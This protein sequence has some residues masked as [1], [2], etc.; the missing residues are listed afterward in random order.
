MCGASCHKDLPFFRDLQR[1]MSGVTEEITTTGAGHE[2][3]WLMAEGFPT[4]S[5]LVPDVRLGV[6]T[7]RSSS[8][9][10]GIPPGV[11]GLICSIATKS[12]LLA[13]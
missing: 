13:K 8:M 3:L 9:H 10:S 5:K 11:E 2:A 4:K 6:P 12:W 1:V 7:T